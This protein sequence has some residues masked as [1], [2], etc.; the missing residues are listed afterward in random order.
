MTHHVTIFHNG[1]VLPVSESVECDSD[2]CVYL[3]EPDIEAGS[4]KMY[5]CGDLRIIVSREVLTATP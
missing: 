1:A 4:I 5:N 2:P 3:G